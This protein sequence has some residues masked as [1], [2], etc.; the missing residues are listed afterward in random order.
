MDFYTIQEEA[1][2]RGYEAAQPKWIPVTEQLPKLESYV[3]SVDVLFYVPYDSIYVGY[4]NLE[5]GTW[6]CKHSRNLFAADKVTHWMPLP[7]SPKG[8]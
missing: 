6:K 1:Y 8:E 7:E 5:S 4:A 2:K 3:Y